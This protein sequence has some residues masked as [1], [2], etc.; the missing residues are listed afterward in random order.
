MPNH[1]FADLTK[2]AIAS[3][4]APLVQGFC[5]IAALQIPSRVPTHTITQYATMG[6]NMLARSVRY[7][8]GAA[9]FPN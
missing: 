3:L 8:E 7:R 1:F 4:A 2:G 5:E 9:N 6:P